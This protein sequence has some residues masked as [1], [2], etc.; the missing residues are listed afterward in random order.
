[1]LFTCPTNLDIWSNYFSLVFMSTRALDMSKV[2]QNVMSLNLS[3]FHLLDSPSKASVF[4]AIT[5]VI[6]AI[7]RAKW[8]SHYDNVGI[9]NQSVVD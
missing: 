5:C 3:S 2:Y 8:R 7:W 6:T 1:M 9:D 4:E